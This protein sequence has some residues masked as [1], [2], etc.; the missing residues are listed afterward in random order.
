MQQPSLVSKMENNMHQG[1]KKILAPGPKSDISKEV[2]NN[3]LVTLTN[4]ESIPLV[5]S[6]N[7]NVTKSVINGFFIQ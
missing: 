3:N 1:R 4:V 7:T 6:G 2:K 5:L